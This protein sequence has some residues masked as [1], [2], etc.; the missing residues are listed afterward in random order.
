MVDNENNQWEDDLEYTEETE[1]TASTED[2]VETYSDTEEYSEEETTG[3]DVEEYGET[4]EY[5]EEDG[6]EPPKKKNSLPIVAAL[7]LL[8]LI[9]GA[10][11]VPKLM[12]KDS[13]D[14]VVN[15][16]MQQ[17]EPN[18]QSNEDLAGSFFDAA[19][20]E[21]AEMTSV[22]FNEEGEGMSFDNNNEQNNFQEGQPQ[23][24]QNEQQ[25]EQQE[26]QPQPTVTEARPGE[27]ITESDLFAD[28]NSQEN[29]SI[30]VVYNKAAR[31]NP[32]KPPVV[33][34]GP[35]Q[36]GIPYETINNTQFEIIE[37][38]TASVPDENL[39][40]LLQ[41]QISGIMYDAQSPAAIVNING[42]DQFVKTGDVIAGYKIEK[43]TRD[44]VQISYKKN[45]YV[46]SVG[47]LFTKGQLEQ[48][49]AVANLEN[50]FA[51]RN[52]NK[53]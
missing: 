51:G 42:V 34:G 36:G 28:Q 10:I 25:G 3:E 32:F 26:Q 46:A 48:Q 39:T 9:G 18:N 19:G 47:E 7:L 33:V 29:D 14:V 16:N 37:P 17:Q 49:Q 27:G 4:E 24:Q 50:K 30:M 5:E 53:N 12:N 31:L 22:N 45:S 13:N 15:N 23:E 44:K 2:G 21:D 40:K 35:A 41:T 8:L 6:E 38:P 1:E 20:G 52:K 43:I 11:A